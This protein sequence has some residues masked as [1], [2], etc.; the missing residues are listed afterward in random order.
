MTTIVLADDHNV[1][2][3][4]LRA[5]LEAEHDITIVG[6]AET[7]LEIIKLVEQMQPDI[8]VVDVMMPELTGLEVARQISEQKLPTRVI[9]LSMYANEAYVLEALRYGAMG[10]VLKHADATELVQ[11]IRAV[12]LGQHYL[13][14]PLSEQAI[15]VYIARARETTSDPYDL[16]T[17]REREVLHLVAQSYSNIEIARRLIISP[18]TVETHRANM[19]QKLDLQTQTDLVKYAVRRGIIPLEE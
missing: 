14:P 4:G 12:M 18:R 8:V 13:S 9:I 2:R 6:E 1:V 15:E 3:Q 10:Y 7:G 19:M 16:L 5:V 11:A 17:P